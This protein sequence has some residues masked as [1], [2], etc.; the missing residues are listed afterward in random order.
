MIADD[1]IR[2]EHGFGYRL[3]MARK[4]AGLSR[5]QLARR[6]D[7]TDRDVRRWETGQRQ[8][9]R[10]RCVVELAKVLSVTIDWLVAG[11]EEKA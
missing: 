4:L 9:P 6:I 10:L 3:Q 2:P 1:E 7:V 8:N 5:A 11:K